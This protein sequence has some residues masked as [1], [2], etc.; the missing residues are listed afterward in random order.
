MFGT[1]L[2]PT[3]HFTSSFRVRAPLEPYSDR[4]EKFQKQYATIKN[5]PHCVYYEHVMEKRGCK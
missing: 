4:K 1:K 3:E 5:G 2:S